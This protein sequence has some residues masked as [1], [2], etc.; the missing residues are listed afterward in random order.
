MGIHNFGLYKIKGE[1]MLKKMFLCFMFFMSVIGFNAYAD[2]MVDNEVF[3]DDEIVVGSVDDIVDEAES[4]PEPEDEVK[5]AEKTSASALE[6]Y[7]IDGS[8]FERITNL[9]Q[10]KIIVQLETERARMDLDLERLNAERAKLQGETES[11]I[12]DVKVQEL[13]IEKEQLAQMKKE[14]EQQMSQM[15]QQM[16]NLRSDYSNMSLPDVV[17]PKPVE[18]YSVA[19]KYQILNIIGVGNQVQATIKDLSTGQNRRIAVGNVIDG[20]KIKSISL[21]DGIVFEKDGFSEN[22]NVGNK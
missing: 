18:S 19:T 10:E 13:E 6:N 2:D 7:N 22:L 5:T 17:T 9:E 1:K 4:Q 12:V 20:H 8:L 16:D 14:M 21:S 11:K 15:K 3:V